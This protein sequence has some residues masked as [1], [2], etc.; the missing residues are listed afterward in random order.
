MPP[1]GSTKN[2]PLVSAGWSIFYEEVYSPK[3]QEQRSGL[4]S[5]L[6]SR[7]SIKRD[8]EVFALCTDSTAVVSNLTSCEGL[9]WRNVIDTY[10]W[11]LR[12][13]S[14]ADSVDVN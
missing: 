13:D 1:S 14:D 5:S 9:L 4:L 11:S 10:W 7:P 8:S 6:K 3:S 2:D 12:I